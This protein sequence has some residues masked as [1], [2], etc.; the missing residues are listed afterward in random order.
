MQGIINLVSFVK[1]ILEKDADFLLAISGAKGTGKSTLG[2]QI[3]RAYLKRFWRYEGNFDTWFKRNLHRF[4]A[5]ETA[6]VLQKIET[7]EDS[8]PILCDEAVRFAMAEDWMKAE[9]KYLKKIFTQIRTKHLFFIFC[10]PEFYWIDRKYREDMVNVWI[11]ILKRGLG[12]AFLPDQ[13]IGVKDKWHRKE[14]LNVN[15]TYTMFDNPENVVNLY[16]KHPCFWDV[17]G[18]MQVEKSVYERYKELRNE[19]L[20]EALTPAYILTY[21]D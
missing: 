3:I 11:H 12:L 19:A 8:Q 9:S 18:F 5:Y 16:K 14:F 20:T 17:I 13:K 15:V 4:V 10:I 6:D 21:W 1:K 2:L 7:A